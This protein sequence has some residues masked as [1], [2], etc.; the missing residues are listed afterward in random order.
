MYFQDNHSE[1]NSQIK[2]DNALAVFLL[3]S[4]AAWKIPLPEIIPGQVGTT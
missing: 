4:A 1:V 3:Q 2:V